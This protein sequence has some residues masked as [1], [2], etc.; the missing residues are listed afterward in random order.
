MPFAVINTI[1][2]NHEGGLLA[3]T[4]LSRSEL[5]SIIGLYVRD[6]HIPEDQAQFYQTLLNT[7]VELAAYGI[8]FDEQN[9]QTVPHL[10]TEENAKYSPYRRDKLPPN[11]VAAITDI[12]LMAQSV[13]AGNPVTW[14]YYGRP[15]PYDK[16]DRWTLP[17]EGSA[18][19]I[20]PTPTTSP[21]A[22]KPAQAGMTNYLDAPA[23]G[24]R[25]LL[26]MGD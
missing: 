26:G 6:G 9:I 14:G 25:S 15:I 18:V 3:M 10:Y 1:T 12:G 23:Q 8:R 24:L 2:G 16:H 5:N 21:P 13:L 7:Q 17:G 19:E 11:T 4:D 22:P 20:P